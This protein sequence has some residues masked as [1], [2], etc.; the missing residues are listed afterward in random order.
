MAAPKVHINDPTY[1]VKEAIELT[2]LTPTQI[3]KTIDIRDLDKNGNLYWPEM[4][5]LVIASKAI[6]SL[7]P[8]IISPGTQR[9]IL[10]LIMAGPTPRA[11]TCIIRPDGTV[12]YMAT[13]LTF[14]PNGIAVTWDGTLK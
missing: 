3:T 5:K 10:K 12:Y 13:G 14:K 7:P 6:A 4:A 9:R 1:T 2:G 8:T 11:G